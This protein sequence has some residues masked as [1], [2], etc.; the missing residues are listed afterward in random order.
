MSEQGQ[1][2]A[3][4]DSA[5]AQLRD[6][7]P[8]AALLGIELLRAE[9][10]LVR[11]RLEWAP[12]RCTAGGLLHGGAPMAVRDDGAPAA[13]VIQTQIFHFPRSAGE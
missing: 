8:L 1:A 7:M 5:L 11:A 13:K 2:P 6:T 4:S 9:S 12:E 3:V 10:E